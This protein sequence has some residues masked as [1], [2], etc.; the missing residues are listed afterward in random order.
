[1]VTQTYKIKISWWKT[2]LWTVIN[3]NLGYFYRRIKLYIALANERESEKII[4]RNSRNIVFVIMSFLIWKYTYNFFGDDQFARETISDTRISS[5]KSVR[6][7]FSLI[8]AYNEDIS[9]LWKTSPCFIRTRW[10]FDWNSEAHVERNLRIS[11]Q[12]WI[13]KM[14]DGENHVYFHRLIR[15]E[16]ICLTQT[17]VLLCFRITTSQCIF[18]IDIADLRVVSSIRSAVRLSKLFALSLPLVQRKRNRGTLSCLPFINE[19]RMTT[20]THNL[21]ELP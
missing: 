11:P 12:M 15:I 6:E 16:L 7:S 1:M 5:P 18:G 3:S 20:H 21:E 2:F 8:Y 4:K 14:L 13:I 17:C 10:T 19:I 9:Y